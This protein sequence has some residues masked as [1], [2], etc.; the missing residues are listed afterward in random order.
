MNATGKHSRPYSISFIRVVDNVAELRMSTVVAI[1]NPV[2]AHGAPT[3]S[4][5]DPPVDPDKTDHR[6]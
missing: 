2:V 3:K 1:Q 6:L 5:S 4:A